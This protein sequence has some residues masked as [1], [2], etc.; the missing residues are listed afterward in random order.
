ML[1]DRFL[2]DGR[3]SNAQPNL[4]AKQELEVRVWA[5]KEIFR[6]VHFLDWSLS[7]Q[8]KD[9]DPIHNRFHERETSYFSYA[10]AEEMGW[11][12]KDCTRAEYVGLY[13]DKGYGAVRSGI[14]PHEQHAYASAMLMAV[15]PLMWFDVKDAFDQ[16]FRQEAIQAVLNHPE[17]KLPTN[18]GDLAKVVQSADRL[19]GLPPYAFY[20]F[21]YYNGMRHEIFDDVFR[22]SLPRR[23]FLRPNQVDLRD[24]RKVDIQLNKSNQIVGTSYMAGLRQS[25]E[26]II[27][28]W[29]RENHLLGE[30]REYGEI[31][32]S[33]IYGVED[34][35]DPILPK[36]I[37]A[38]PVKLFIANESLSHLEE[39]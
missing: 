23:G 17:D 34:K 39:F 4:N 36:A 20:S 30:A 24:P 31:T 7:D 16:K 12:E 22:Y 26:E 29:L 27:F 8:F 3:D 13:L 19:A 33:R 6:N 15:D 9:L 28:P 35:V 38:F 2:Y 18:A 1:H 10:I 25:C 5:Y 37:N 21:A 14:I 11:S 32:I